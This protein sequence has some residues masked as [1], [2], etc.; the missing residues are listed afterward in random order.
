MGASRVVGK[1]LLGL[2]SFFWGEEEE[3]D[4]SEIKWRK[5]VNGEEGNGQGF[6]VWG[7]WGIER[8]KIGFFR[9]IYHTC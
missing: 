6:L 2:S 1:S 9:N 4:A 3:Y 7:K 8:R 5:H